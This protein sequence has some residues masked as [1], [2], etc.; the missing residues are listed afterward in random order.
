M[1]RRGN[2][3]NMRT[4]SIVVPVYYGQKYITGLIKQTEAEKELLGPED[5]VELI[6]VNDAPD[7]PLPTSYDSELIEITVL[8]TEHNRGIQ[9]ARVY[10]IECCRG[11]YVHML[12]QDD[13][14]APDFL[15]SQLRAI[16][17]YDASVCRAI[18]DKK[19]VYTDTRPFESVS[20]LEY[21]LSQ[22]DAIVSP[23]QVLIKKESISQIWKENH[24]KYNGAD[25]WLLWICMLAEGKRFARNDKVLYEHVIDGE[26]NSWQLEKMMRS[27]QE[28]AEVLK[29]EHV[30]G[31]ADIK[32][33]TNTLFEINIKRIANI[34]KFRAMFFICNLWLTL[35]NKNKSVY[36]Y[37]QENGFH[38][39]AIYGNGYLGKL[40]YEELKTQNVYISYF[41]DRDAAYMDEE[42]P[43]YTLEDELETVDIIIVT[44]TKKDENFRKVLTNKAQTTVWYLEDLLNKVL[45][46]E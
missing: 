14:I 36:G 15:Q 12:D 41:I 2:N 28:V 27:E 6:L 40:L 9:G 3:F 25:D 22:G 19:Q 23:G 18:H 32:K 30:L 39:I 11:Q 34:E 29:R 10:G 42:V 24:L 35:K 5:S 7:D 37:L 45:M 31:E 26:N 17:G 16:D 1:D 21:M 13:R 8:N 43:V 38:E 4:V 33:L 44:L 46:G 20:S